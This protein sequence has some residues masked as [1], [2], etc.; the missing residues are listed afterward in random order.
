MSHYYP[1]R[2]VDVE[3]L[4]GSKDPR[5]VVTEKKHDNFARY[6]AL[7][8]CWG[9]PQALQSQMYP[10]TVKNNIDDFR[11]GMSMTQLPQTFQDAIVVVRNLGIRYLWIDAL[12]IIQDD[13]E[14]WARE[15]VKMDKVYGDA[16]L[17]I[18]A[19]ST[20]SDV[21]GFLHRSPLP[22]VVRMPYQA[23]AAPE[24]GESH[25][26]LSY[27]RSGGNEGSWS[28]VF[29]ESLWSTRGWTFQEYLL[30]KRV[31]HFTS[32]KIFWECRVI[33]GSEENEPPRT[34]QDETSWMKQYHM[35]GLRNEV[36][37][38]RVNPDSRFDPRFDQWYQV[39]SR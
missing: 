16:F 23:Y 34:T 10:R 12:C 19:T 11:N 28:R 38:E 25:Y 15:A 17:T 6:A 8:H 31:L 20:K 1:T 26:Y 3:P 21:E 9:A 2:L 32:T 29:N 5:L 39:L 36:P 27:R 14:D 35:S 7:S 37:N 33:E 13:K 4:D 22:P 30:S 24:T 18:V